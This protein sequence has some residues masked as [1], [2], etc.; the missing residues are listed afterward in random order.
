[1]HHFAAVKIHK[2]PVHFLTCPLLNCAYLSAVVYAAETI[3]A[4]REQSQCHPFHLHAA[5]TQAE[6]V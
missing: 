6:L 3:S 5:Q 1:M 4:V 2:L